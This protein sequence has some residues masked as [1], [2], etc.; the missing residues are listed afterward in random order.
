MQTTLTTPSPSME[1]AE[2]R[3]ETFE[4]AAIVARDYAALARKQF[5]GSKADAADLADQIVKNEVALDGG[6]DAV[7]LRY[8]SLPKVLRNLRCLEVTTGYLPETILIDVTAQVD[9]EP[10]VDAFELI[11]WERA[12]V[13]NRQMGAVEIRCRPA[14]LEEVYGRWLLTMDVEGTVKS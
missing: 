13:V 5:R 12:A 10:H 14:K 3:R 1:K 7:L 8:D 2:K 11:T 4:R 6:C 9:D